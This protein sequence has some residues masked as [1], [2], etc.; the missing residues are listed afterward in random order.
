MLHRRFVHYLVAVIAA[1]VVG[2]PLIA[3]D[4][5]TRCGLLSSGALAILFA[6]MIHL[7]ASA[8]IGRWIWGVIAAI[9]S[10]GAPLGFEMCMSDQ[11]RAWW[12]GVGVIFVSLS[13]L[14]AWRSHREAQGNV[15]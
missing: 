7:G 11:P 5:S 9:L 4:Q 13:A 8:G 12:L 2:W 10:F 6:S 15:T 14:I 1:L 3:E